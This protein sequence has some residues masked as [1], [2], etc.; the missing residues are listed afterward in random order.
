[1]ILNLT[2][3]ELGWIVI[4]RPASGPILPYI[5]ELALYFPIFS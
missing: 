5:F 3:H 4:G 1:M 2:K